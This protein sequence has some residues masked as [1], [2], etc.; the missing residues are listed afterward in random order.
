MN[1]SKLWTEQEIDFLKKNYP[2]YGNNYCRKHLNRSYASVKWKSQDL[3]L[4]VIDQAKIPRKQPIRKQPN[5]DINQ[6]ITVRSP[7]VAYILGFLWGDGYIKAYKPGQGK[8]RRVAHTVRLQIVLNDLNNIKNSFLKIGE[9]NIRYFKSRDHRQPTGAISTCHN[10]LTN[11]LIQKDYL[12]KSFKTAD[13]IL[14]TIPD[15]LKHYWFRGLF[16]ADGSLSYSKPNIQVAIASGYTQDWAYM[17]NLSNQLNISYNI[18]RGVQVFDDRTHKHSSFRYINNISI[19]VFLNY[20]YQNRNIDQIGLNRKYNKFLEFND[21][22]QNIFKSRITNCIKK[23]R[24]NNKFQYAFTFR[25]VRY[26]DMHCES[27][28]D[29]ILKKQNRFL[30]ELGPLEFERYFGFQYH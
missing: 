23:N 1:I 5:I 26:S 3:K 20:I 2:T 24:Y 30:K 8:E 13:K 17:I 10:A 22:M 18:S 15:N 14:E 12:V 25:G 27:L 9:W 21:H 29:A 6:F 4:L 16:D 11:Y 28:D 7:E 19:F